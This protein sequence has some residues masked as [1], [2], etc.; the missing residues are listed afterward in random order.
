MSLFCPVY[1]CCS[2]LQCVAVCCSVWQCVAVRG[3]AWQC[4]AM[5]CSAL[6]CVAVRCSALQ[7]VAVRCSALQCVA[8]RYRVMQ[9][10]NSICG[11][12]L[13]VSLSCPESVYMGWLQLVGS[14][15]LYVAFAEEPN[16]R[17]DILRKKPISLRSLLI[18][19]TS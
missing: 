10:F 14:L 16:K 8:V 7:Y 4:V 11:S 19:A 5:H 18:V 17:D 9:N 6:H 15:K 13:R 3:S 1:V 12:T 2:V